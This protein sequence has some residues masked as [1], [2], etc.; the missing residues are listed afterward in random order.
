MVFLSTVRMRYSDHVRRFKA[1]AT[2]LAEQGDSDGE[3]RNLLH[4]LHVS[5]GSDHEVLY[6][7]GARSHELD[8]T[9][10]A[11]A[12]YE[13]AE[14]LHPSD[15]LL[16][17]N[18]GAAYLMDGRYR[19]AFRCFRTALALDPHDVNAMLNSLELLGAV[20]RTSGCK[21]MLAAAPEGVRKHPQIRELAA[22]YEMKIES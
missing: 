13:R 11:I 21:A 5:D 9:D 16:L 2:S 14:A 8:R 7:L 3:L 10:E 6:D 22:E 19:L 15:P 18:L 1:R 12:W 20:G 17:S 4:A